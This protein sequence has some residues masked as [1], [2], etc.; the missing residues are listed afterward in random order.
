MNT[1]FRLGAIATLLGLTACGSEPVHYYTLLSPSTSAAASPQPA[2]FL[3]EVLPVGIPS[4]L[5]QELL[6]VRQGA[7]GLVMLYGERWASPLSDEVR[8]AVS[9]ELSQRLGAQDTA[10]LPQPAGRPLL[11]IKLQIRRFDA[12][13]GLRVQL[14]ADWTLGF[15]DDNTKN[16]LL[17]H[18]RFG[19]PADG[20]YPEMVAAQQRAI[21]TLAAKIEADA[22]QWAQS[23]NTACS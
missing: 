20:G 22:L 17:C 4:N 23:R 21:A 5:D 15:A 8:D 19:Q 14:D 3:I 10:G 7:S 16:R 12:W 2:D 9:A 13:P 1:L 11:R 6:V 18:G